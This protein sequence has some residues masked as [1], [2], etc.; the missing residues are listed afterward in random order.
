MSP[1]LD[2]RHLQMLVEIARTG[3]VTRAAETIGLTQSALTHRIREA[4][5]RLGLTLYTRVGRGLRMTPAGETLA[6]CAERVLEELERAE[7]D[8]VEMS[9]GI[10]H[11][12]RIGIGAY[13]RYHWLPAFLNTPRVPHGSARCASPTGRDR[14]PAARMEPRRLR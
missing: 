1:R 12:V 6:Y 8:A 9:R 13:T 2:I 10:D 5:R 3:N 11:V 4:E 14:P 7:H